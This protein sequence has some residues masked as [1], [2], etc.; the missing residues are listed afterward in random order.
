[1]EKPETICYE[2]PLNEHTRICLRL[3]QLFHQI[4]HCLAGESPWDSHAC[5]AALLDVINIIDRPDLKTKLT[6]EFKQYYNQLGRIR[7]NPGIDKFKLGKTCD[8]L[9][10]LIEQLYLVSG[11]IGQ[12]LRDDQFLNNVRQHLL[13]PGASCRFDTPSYYYWLHRPAK[14]RQNDLKHWN[15]E[16]DLLQRSV[17]MLLHLIRDSHTPKLVTA[18]QGFYQD[19]LDAQQA[20]QLIRVTLPIKLSIVP[21]ISASRHR[22]S[23]RFYI[24]SN[25]DRPTPYH[26][27]LTFELSCCS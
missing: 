15:K 20:C 3:E 9:G 26:E 12:A 24:P 16:L 18:E 19:S 4:Q 8:D 27:E 22:F 6:Q 13:S 17:N 1:M 14:Q 11:K 21:D 10:L 7:D 23:I 2:Q 5:L 25:T